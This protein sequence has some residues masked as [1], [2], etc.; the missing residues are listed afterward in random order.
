[1]MAGGIEGD[2]AVGGETITTTAMTIAATKD[3]NV[4]VFLYAGYSRS[5]PGL[6]WRSEDT[7]P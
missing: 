7:G 3:D 1:M 6:Q 5:L 2:M 4:P